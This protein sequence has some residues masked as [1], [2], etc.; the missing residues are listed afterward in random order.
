L[1]AVISDT[2][3]LIDYIVSN[4][5][6]LSVSCEKLYKFII[7]TPIFKEIKQ[8]PQEEAINLGMEI[9]EPSLKQVIEANQRDGKLSFYDKLCFVVAR[10]KKCICATNDKVLK[11]YCT[12]NNVDT[13]WGLEI[14]LR[15]Y[16][17]NFLEK[18]TAV[19]TARDIHKSNKLI[20]KE[21]L[22]TFIAKINK[23]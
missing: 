7:P 14:M 19:E 11:N 18:K 23:L 3:I 8:L 9:Y 15:L 4:K 20:T 10:D 2:N 17:N 6:I 16:E 22:E 21:V 5:Y 12:N 1:T 13:I